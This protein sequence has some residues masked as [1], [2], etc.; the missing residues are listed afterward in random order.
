V[1]RSPP[2]G[3][4]ERLGDLALDRKPPRLLPAD[5]RP[6]RRRITAYAIAARDN[7]SNRTGARSAT[8][9]IRT[10]LQRGPQRCLRGQAE[11]LRHRALLRRLHWRV[12]GRPGH[13]DEG[14]RRRQRLRRG[15]H[16]LRPVNLPGQGGPQPDQGRRARLGRHRRLRGQDRRGVSYPPSG[17]GFARS[18]HPRPEHPRSD[19]TRPRPH[20]CR[21]GRDGL[22]ADQRPVRGRRGEDPA[23]ADRPWRRAG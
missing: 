5:A 21:P 4:A 23:A 17:T 14:G 10:R 11:P 7:V 9:R 22:Q 20:R 15:H 18:E 8:I 16:Q 2:A 6:G 13:R 1:A 12:G 19:S 3:W